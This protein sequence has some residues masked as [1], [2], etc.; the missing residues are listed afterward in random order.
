MSGPGTFDSISG[1]GG[2]GGSRESL[3][4]RRLELSVN[5][6]DGS[7]L[8]APLTQVLLASTDALYQDLYNMAHGELNVTVTTTQQTTDDAAG[9]NADDNETAAAASATRA[10]TAPTKRERM[11]NLSFAQRRHELAWRLAMHGKALQQVSALT[12]ANA[13][14]DFASAVAVSSRALQHARTAWIQADEAQDALYFFH[15]QLFPV[16]DAPHDVYGALDVQLA[17]AWFDLPHDLAL[18]VDRY[19]TSDESTWRKEEVDQRW[20]LAVRDK[21]VRGEVGW[22]KLKIYQ[23]QQT[24]LPQS[25][26]APAVADELSIAP[27]P[28][29]LT[30]R[31]GILQLTHGQPKCLAGQDDL[32]PITAL[33]T[34]LSPNTIA[35]NTPANEALLSALPTTA[36]T[37]HP[38][39][40]ITTTARKV[41][42][43]KAHGC[44]LDRVAF[45]RGP[46]TTSQS[47]CLSG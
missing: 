38:A 19:E 20:Q 40:I 1:G 8:T 45:P 30:L 11:S 14:S 46:Y 44:D 23:Q 47:L 29:K 10:A 28:W 2:G 26:S 7:L 32:Y 17:R 34:V 42:I 3:Q 31:G 5:P 27:L 37:T 22:R 33:L 9:E 39:A 18:A 21:L 35:T 36:T 15:A 4:P 25:L 6:V 12:A 13:S 41:P 24:R 43:D 16:R